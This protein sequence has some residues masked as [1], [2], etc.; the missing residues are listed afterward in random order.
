VSVVGG[1]V[2]LLLFPLLVL[3]KALTPADVTFLEKNLG[4]IRQV[5]PFTK[6][7]IRYYRAFL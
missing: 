1:A 2:Y 5:A 7:T 6:L 3:A 4:S